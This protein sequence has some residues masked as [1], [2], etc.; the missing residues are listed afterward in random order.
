MRDDFQYIA[1]DLDEALTILLTRKDEGLTLSADQAKYIY[2]KVWNV[3]ATL[4]DLGLINVAPI[5]KADMN[6]IT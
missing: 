1:D 3:E 2:R 4:T 5:T 6:V